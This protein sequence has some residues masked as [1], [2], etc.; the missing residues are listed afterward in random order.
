VFVCGPITEARNGQGLDEGLRSFL[1]LVHQLLERAGIEVVSAHRDERW[2]HDE[3]PP[4]I[5]AKRDFAWMKAC[6]AAVMVLGTPAQPVWRTD[7]TFMELGWATSVDKPVVLIGDLDSYRSP[8]VRGLPSL[9]GRIRILTPQE[10]QVRPEVVLGA[11]S[12]SMSTSSAVLASNP[13]QGTGR[14]AFEPTRAG[15]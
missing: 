10:V 15:P 13:L 3:P 9:S 6:S 4:E 5:I 2:G 8:L 1:E 7:G 14:P 11:L 12:Q